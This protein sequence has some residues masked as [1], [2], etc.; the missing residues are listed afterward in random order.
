MNRSDLNSLE[1]GI[2]LSR[3]LDHTSPHSVSAWTIADDTL[4]LVRAAKALH[5]LYEAACNGELTKRQR[6]SQKTLQANVE[7]LL[8][9]YGLTCEHQTDPRGAPVTILENGFR[10]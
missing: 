1:L 5:R 9:T 2:R 6:A 4:K 3:A 10:F 8:G 7:R